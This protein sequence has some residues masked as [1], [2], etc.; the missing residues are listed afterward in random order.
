MILGRLQGVPNRKAQRRRDKVHR[1]PGRWPVPAPWR[2]RRGGRGRSSRPN[3]RAHGEEQRLRNR[4]DALSSRATSRVAAPRGPGLAVS[5]EWRTRLRFPPSAACKMPAPSIMPTAPGPRSARCRPGM[6]PILAEDL[7]RHARQ[8][9]PPASPLLPSVA[10]PPLA[11]RLPSA[12]AGRQAAD[13]QF[14]EQARPPELGD[15]EPSGLNQ[16]PS[17]FTTLRK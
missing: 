10:Y 8:A 16:E 5:G 7:S 15:S 3:A 17:W 13:Q 4:P 14:G 2:Y 6:S 9:M 1:A 11:G 12:L